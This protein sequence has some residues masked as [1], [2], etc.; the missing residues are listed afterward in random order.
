[1][2]L[3]QFKWWEDGKTESLGTLKEFVHVTQKTPIS[4]IACHFHFSRDVAPMSYNLKTS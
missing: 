3:V 4:Q 1:M 2:L